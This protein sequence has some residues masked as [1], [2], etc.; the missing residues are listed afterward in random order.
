EQFNPA[1]TPGKLAKAHSQW[2]DYHAKKFRENWLALHNVPDPE[3]RLKLGF[4]SAQFTR[5][6][7]GALLVRAVEAVVARHCDVV[8]YSGVKEPDAITGRF[9][10]LARPWRDVRSISDEALA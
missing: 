6:P 4:V 3:R 9:T 1:V 5:R 7:I 2:N 10:A 8:C